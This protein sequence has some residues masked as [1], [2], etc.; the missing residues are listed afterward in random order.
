MA[1]RWFQRLLPTVLRSAIGATILT[2][3]MHARL[4]AITDLIGSRAASSSAQAPGMDGAGAAAGTA[5]AGAIAVAMATVAD[6]D[7]AAGMDTA[8][9]TAV[10]IE[11]EL[12]REASAAVDTTAEWQVAVTALPA[13]VDSTEVA[14]AS[15]AVVAE[16]STVVAEAVT[17]KT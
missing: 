17:G 9:V 7:I 3:R 6:M 12:L 15:T 5:V 8:A 14:A 2:I 13:V 4:T 10:D 16:A 11:V 1:R